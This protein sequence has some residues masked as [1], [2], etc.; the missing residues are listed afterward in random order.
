MIEV[1]ELVQRQ[2]KYM[3][4]LLALFVLGWGFT[5]YKDVFLGL[6][7]GTI[8]GFLSLR[9]VAH[10]TDRLLDRV[11]QGENVKYKATAVSTYS[12][13]AT[14]GLLIIFAAK[15]QYLI[16]MWSLGVGLLTG[17]L[18]MI[19]DFLYLQYKSREER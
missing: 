18:V 12:R 6:I 14:I 15:Y 4:N 8:F 9:I 19:I 13:L 1:H 10:K 5:S 2:K 11:T 17:Y 16:A 7:I 3:Y